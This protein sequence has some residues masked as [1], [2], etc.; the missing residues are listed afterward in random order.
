MA[1]IERRLKWIGC[2]DYDGLNFTTTVVNVQCPGTVS[3]ETAM[4]YSW[5]EDTAGFTR[6]GIEHIRYRDG[7]R[8]EFFLEPCAIRKNVEAVRFRVEVGHARVRGTI[9]VDFWG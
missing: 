4:T 3:I 8:E 1:I 6:V 2:W 9:T 5:I 7:S